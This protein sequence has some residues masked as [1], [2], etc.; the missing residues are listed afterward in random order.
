MIKTDS[1]GNEIWNVTF[2]RVESE[3]IFSC[4][5]GYIAQTDD[6]GYLVIGE[7]KRIP[8][9]YEETMDF[10]PEIWLIKINQDG[11]EEWNVTFPDKDF[12]MAKQTFDGGLII[13]GKKKGQLFG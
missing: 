7:V 3:R 9:T 13:V 10:W 8:L 6:G 12:R 2:K 4:R 5:G 1:D 11:M